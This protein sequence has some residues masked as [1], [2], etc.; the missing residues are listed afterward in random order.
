MR[1]RRVVVRFRAGPAWESG[2][3]EEQ[4]DWDAHEAFVDD[5][6]DRGIFVMGGPF[7]DYSGSMVLLEGVDAEEARRLLAP[8][9]F[10]HNG[11]FVLES[12][13]EWTVYVDR[14]SAAAASGG[15]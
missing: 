4:A 1:R 12:V 2:P 5:L 14:L 6:V 7:G 11:V 8:D 15:D 13:Q 3:P 10:L 9:P